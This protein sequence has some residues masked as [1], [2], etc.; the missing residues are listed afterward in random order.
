MQHDHALKKLN[1]DL[2]SPGSAGGGGGGRDGVCGQI[3]CFHVAAF[4]IPFDMQHKRILD[5]LNFDL[6]PP[7]SGKGGLRACIRNS[8]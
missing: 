3:I 2:L 8:L 7:G 4:A 6:L 1:F 5:K